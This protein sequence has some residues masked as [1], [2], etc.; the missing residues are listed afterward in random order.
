MR[1]CTSFSCTAI[2]SSGSEFEGCTDKQNVQ[3]GTSVIGFPRFLKRRSM[4][5]RLAAVQK[6]VRELKMGLII[7]EEED[8][9]LLL[10][11][12]FLPDWKK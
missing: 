10:Q 2:S 8:I 11:A 3:S 1:V 7:S 5:A 4:S 12:E 9:L 6:L